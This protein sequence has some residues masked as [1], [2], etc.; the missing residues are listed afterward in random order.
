MLNSLPCIASSTPP[1][2]YGY[3][4]LD[5]SEPFRTSLL[6]LQN[7]FHYQTAPENRVYLAYLTPATA[8][9]PPVLVS[10]LAP[11]PACLL[12]RVDAVYPRL[13]SVS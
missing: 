11:S 5:P 7:P 10:L 9:R 3:A 2:P 6:H 12:P 8:L 1:H 13:R 4:I